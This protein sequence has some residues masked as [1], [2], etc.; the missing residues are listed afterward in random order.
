MR[1]HHF[2]GN[3]MWNALSITEGVVSALNAK[4]Y[5]CDDCEECR[6]VILSIQLVNKFWVI[7]DASIVD[8]TIVR[9]KHDGAGFWVIWCYWVP[10]ETLHNRHEYSDW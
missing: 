7:D 3:R 9:R 2:N 5:R 10:F 6:N 4:T 8:F 1:Q